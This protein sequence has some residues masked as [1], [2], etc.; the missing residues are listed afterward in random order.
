MEAGPPT[1]RVRTLD[2]EEARALLAPYGVALPRQELAA[3]ADAAARAAARVGFPVA[4][5]AVADGLLHRSDVGGVRLGLAGA[6]AVRREA[7][8]LAAR[9]PGLRAFLVQEMVEPGIELIVG[10]RRDPVF[11]PVVLAGLGGIWVEVMAD[12]TLR[13][14]PLRP[15]DAE[16]MLDELRGS[17][18]LRGAR[19]RPGVDRSA[20]VGLLEAV[21][22]L[23]AERND[24][25]ELDLN[26]VIAG[27]L[28]AVAVDAKVVLARTEAVP[29]RRSDTPADVAV[30]RL[31]APESIAVVGASSTRAKQ[32]G[33]LFH[34]LVKH[35]FAGRLYAVNPARSEVMGKPSV[36]TVDDLPETPDL[37]CI[38]VPADAASE[39]LD[40][41][42]RKGVRSAIVYA[43]GFAES[44]PAGALKEGELAEAAR[45]SGVRI[46][47]PNTAGVVNTERALCAAIGMAFEVDEIPRGGVSFLTQS[48]ALGSALLSRCWSQGLGFSKWIATGNAA[49][50]DLS[51]Y[52]SYLVDDPATHV[53]ALF[54]E[55]I[56]DAETFLAAARRAKAR[57]KPIVAYKTGASAL[58]QRAVR[59]HTASLAGDDAV[60][61]AAFRSCGVVR[62][63]DLQ[64]LVDA[65]VALSWQPLPRGRRVGVLAAS[66]GACSVV[67]DECA[68][69]GLELPAFGA[70]AHRRIAA[71]IPSFGVSQNPID[72]TMEITVNPS[73]AGRLAEIVL[74]D[75]G[76]D[77]LIVLLT[78]NADPPAFEIAKGVVNAAR[79][80]DKPVL[81]TRVGAEFLAP[82]SVA[83]YR[84]SHIPLFVMPDQVVR[85]L[86][87]MVEFGTIG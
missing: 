9:I 81:V 79:G 43:S 61:S 22:R 5:K 50:L 10:A 19:G 59:S 64:A 70:E 18:L 4:L 38:A 62:V 67:A 21:G 14:A 63:N 47:G 56:R 52:L 25:A 16:S 33:R 76:I 23:A 72:M 30:A 29:T 77:A 37:V 54:V 26:P 24:L 57:G 6:D 71:L 60:Y 7:G 84:E 27:L 31:L 48:G 53:I 78:T 35:G 86:R 82:R 51:D 41:C 85:A 83:F 12:T 39:V 66:G 1:Q 8:D 34:Y 65:A 46:C 2:P 44:G 11:G 69:H 58:G 3:T 13:L 55:A 68:R 17:S 75:P 28:G 73:V 42:G 20:L 36:P 40:A 15:G 45:R 49:D 87:V 74:E 32:G 80:S